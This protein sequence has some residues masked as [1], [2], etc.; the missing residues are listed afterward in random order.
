[1]TLQFVVFKTHVRKDRH[2]GLGQ[3]VLNAIKSGVQH[4]FYV[5]TVIHLYL[6]EQVGFFD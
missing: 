1:M 3:L 2:S 6:V 5:K 4:H